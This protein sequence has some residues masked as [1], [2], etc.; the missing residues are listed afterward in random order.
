MALTTQQVLAASDAWLWVPD[1]AR[2]EVVA[3]VPVVDYPDWAHTP[4]WAAPLD[5]GRPGAEAPAVVAAVVA[6]ARERRKPWMT[7]WLSPSARP[8]ELVDA[9][10]AV[11]AVPQETCDLAACDLSDGVPD[12]GD[13]HH[14]RTQVV[15]DASGLDD[16]N[17]VGDAVWGGVSDPRGRRET[18]L[19]D[20]ARPLAEQDSRR[21]VGYLDGRPVAV[22]GL[23]VADGV[24]RLFGAATLP[25]AR[26]R[27]AY[28]AVLHRRL[29]EARTL[30]ATTALVHARVGTSGPIL[31]RCGFGAYGVATAYRLE[32]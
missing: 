3:D 1:Q 14:V 12:V 17:A 30:G 32:L 2:C 15:A 10:L 23:Q 4:F 29:A 24:A 26:G 16:F 13:V 7:W 8:A 11:G 19:A 21:V 9:L 5:T 28:R 18:Q 27:G 25:A 31:R 20:L 6:A 22:G